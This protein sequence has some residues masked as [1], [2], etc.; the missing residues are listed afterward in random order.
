MAENMARCPPLGVGKNMPI[1]EST[2]K[3]MAQCP[4]L[5]VGKN[6]R[7]RIYRQ[8][9]CPFVAPPESTAQSTGKKSGPAPTPTPRRP[10]SG[11]VNGGL[12]TRLYSED[13]TLWSLY[14]DRP[15]LSPHSPPGSRE[16]GP[17]L[18]RPLARQVR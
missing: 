17:A 14:R 15:I 2:A 11:R 12:R 18:S 1:T 5:G 3:S 16:V 9:I 13:P 6:L 4:P 7:A 10:G 8:K